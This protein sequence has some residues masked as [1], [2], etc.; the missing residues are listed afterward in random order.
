MRKFGLTTSIGVFAALLL[1]FAPGLHAESKLISAIKNQDKAAIRTL[2]QQAAEVNAVEADGTTPLHWAAYMDDAETAGLLIRAS[3]NAKATNRYGVAPI[4]L[5]AINGNAVLM[6]VL[7]KA[8]ADAN[9]TL[10]DGETPL[11]T[12]ART[13]KVDAVKILLAAGANPNAQEKSHKQTALMWA[14]SEGHTAVVL[15]LLQGKAELKARETG[16][17]TAFLYAVRAGRADTVQAMLKAGADVNEAALYPPA[18]GRRDFVTPTGGRGGASAGGGPTALVLAVANAHFELA[19]MLLDAGADPNA[20]AQGWTALHQITW[21]RKPGFGTNQPAPQGSGKLDSL[22]LVQKLV[23]KG[24]NINAKMTK[25]ADMGTTTLNNIDATPFFLA[26]R[27]RDV[28]LMKLFVK[29]GADPKTPNADYTTPLMAAAGV[30]TYSPG[31]D[32]G[33]EEEV[34][35]AVKLAIELGNDP[36]DIDDNGETA[37]H[38][39]AYREF[40][41]LVKLLAEKGAKPEI[42]NQPNKYGWTPLMIAEGV[43]RQNNIHSSPETAAALK[44]VM[45][46]KQ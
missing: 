32:P 16:G 23:A 35:A 9:A 14:A 31:D 29:L 30:G 15:A 34:L 12:T 38:G 28:E 37:M 42:Y 21:V 6:D 7:L 36:N 18:T 27:T 40:P 45:A 17:F 11:M 24:A 39:A 44:E 43:R 19:S 26:C 8:G 5:A 41:A 4:N 2:S 13:G 33:T 25:K 3:A 10:P 22:E 20:A 46:K 1:A